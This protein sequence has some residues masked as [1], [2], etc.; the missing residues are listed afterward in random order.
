[1]KPTV[2]ATAELTYRLDSTKDL[3]KIVNGVLERSALILQPY[4]ESIEPDGEISLIY[5]KVA[6]KIRYSHSVMKK[7][8]RG[9]Y[10][11]QEEFGGSVEKFNPSSDAMNAAKKAL[12]A[13]P[14]EWA[15]ARVDLVDWT[16]RPKV[17]ELELIEPELFFRLHSDA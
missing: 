5:F 6:G 9:E 13:I 4:V 8:K 16:T 11:V 15:Y 2:S 7:A 3:E 10:R 12:D 1:M 14:H 17:G